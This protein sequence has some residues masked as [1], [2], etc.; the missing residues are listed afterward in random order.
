[1]V[2]GSD[3][4]IEVAIHPDSKRHKAPK[5]ITAAFMQAPFG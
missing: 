1:M 5:I 3:L 2:S 4:S